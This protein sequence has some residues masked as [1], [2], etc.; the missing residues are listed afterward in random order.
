MDKNI[1]VIVVGAGIQGL[2]AAKTYIACDPSVDLLILDLNA[3]VGGVWAKEKMYP[4]LR[5]NNLLGTLEF[6]DFPMHAGF[7]VKKEEHIPGETLH[8]YLR[9]YAEKFDL[10]RRITFNTK[11][12]TAE[13]VEEGWRLQTSTWE[14][15]IPGEHEKKS[16]DQ[17][18]FCKK[19]IVATG[20][21]STPLPLHIRGSESFEA[22]ITTFGSLATSGPPLLADPSIKSVTVVGG[23]K[24]AYDCVYLFASGG[25][26]VDWI[27]RRS[28]H[29]PTYMA[30]PH[31]YLGPFRRWLEKLTS[32]RVMTW[33]SPCIWGDADGFGYVRSLLHGTR[34]GRWAV[35]A[36]W[37]KL[38]SDLLVQTGLDG[39]EELRALIPDEDVFWYA[40]ELGILNYPTDIHDFVTAGQVKVHRQDIARLVG[41]GRVAFTDGTSLNT[42]A[43]VCVTGWEWR[44]TIGFLPKIMHAQWGLPSK[45]FTRTQREVWDILDRR[46]DV[47]I[48]QRFPRLAR[49]PERDIQ[50]NHLQMH[51][52]GGGLEG[53]E[54]KEEDTPWR[55]WRAMVPPEMTNGSDQSL[56]FL[57]FFVTLQGAL[58]AEI[59]SLWAFAWLNG[60]LEKPAMRLSID[61]HDSSTSSTGS[62]SG[63]AGGDEYYETALF[64][65]FGRWR[66]PYG[67]G[68]R[69]PDVAFD[70]LPYLDLLCQDLGLRSW[71]KGWGWV[72]E[73]FGGGYG[74]EDYRGFLGEWLRK[75]KKV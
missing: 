52:P 41:K 2:V 13:K 5:S 8:K 16:Q 59:S 33:F 24:A 71:R 60:R 42:D 55:L 1:D 11:V 66:Y 19:L 65:R 74:Q 17:T 61:H 75:E 56:I 54:V 18:I 67:Y 64:N 32:T 48:L 28:G 36:L 15:A 44:S 21:A 20:V 10:L 53:D 34:W 47:E 27:I 12:R 46:A 63:P 57:G 62:I 4:R 31:V 3:S 29:G 73:V 25:K 58:R 37:A 26:R 49:R 23:S 9:Q 50:R 43:L 72:G 38:R 30:R 6:T 68:A 51:R 35:D 14:P 39:K 69:L 7:G 40:T 70:G 45:D 22:P